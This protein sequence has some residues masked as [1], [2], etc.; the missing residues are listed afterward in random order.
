[1]DIVFNEVKLS[2]LPVPLRAELRRG[3]TLSERTKRLLLEATGGVKLAVVCEAVGCYVE[4]GLMRV[5][6]ELLVVDNQGG[7]QW[8]VDLLEVEVPMEGVLPK[9]WEDS[10]RERLGRCRR[11]LEEL[12]DVIGFCAELVGCA[13]AEL[14]LSRQRRGR[15]EE[16]MPGVVLEVRGCSVRIATDR[17]FLHKIYVDDAGHNSPDTLGDAKWKYRKSLMAGSALFESK[18]VDPSKLSG[19]ILAVKEVLRWDGDGAVYFC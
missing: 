10:L 17:G 1:M 5:A 6:V 3:L 16:G 13:D 2:R 9:G 18:E 12:G 14:L 11:V 4:S 19:A 7:R 15:A 8:A